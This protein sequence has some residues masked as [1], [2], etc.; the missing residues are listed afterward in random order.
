MVL[1]DVSMPEMGGLEAL[2]MIREKDAEA[3]VVI[4]SSLGVRG[5][6]KE[7]HSARRRALHPQAV[8]D[9]QRG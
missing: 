5:Y 6:R 4:V 2:G 7:G 8:Q 1:M 3:K 9:A